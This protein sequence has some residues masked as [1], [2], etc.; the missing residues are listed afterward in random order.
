MWPDRLWLLPARV[1][2]CQCSSFRMESLRLQRSSLKGIWSIP[3]DPAG[4]QSVR[5]ET[6]TGNV[7]VPW[8]KKKGSTVDWTSFS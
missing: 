1:A 5:S 4:I 6:T 2:L 8:P 3:P 7:A